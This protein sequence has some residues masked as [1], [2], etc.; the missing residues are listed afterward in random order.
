MM[1]T[2]RITDPSVLADATEQRRSLNMG[3]FALTGPAIHSY[4]PTQDDRE[5]DADATAA[6]SDQSRA[7]A[8]RARRTGRPAGSDGRGQLAIPCRRTGIALAPDAA[9]ARHTTD[10][11]MEVSVMS[12]R[13]T[14][15]QKEVV[16]ALV[17]SNAINFDAVGSVLS[18][19]GAR[20]ALNGDALGAIIHWRLIDICIP[21]EPYLARD[22]ERVANSQLAV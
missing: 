6:R 8:R 13:R 9:L 12:H 1:I 3:T 7:R 17:S 19:F 21:P 20:A 11:N 2:C 5:A 10:R 18:K 14:E 4:T 16:E 15:L 22:L